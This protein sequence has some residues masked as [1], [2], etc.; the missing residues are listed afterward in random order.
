MAKQRKETARHDFSRRE[1]LGTTSSFAIL[2]LVCGT[3][4]LTAAANNTRPVG[5][6][7]VGLGQA[8]LGFA[9]PALEN[10][11]HCRLTALVSQSIEKAKAVADQLGLSHNVAYSDQAFDC[12][13][14]DPMIDVVYLANPNAQHCDFA[15]RA[16]QAGK[17]VLVESPMA[18][19]SQEAI[20]MLDAC[21]SAGT[22]LA[23]IDR[24]AARFGFS[25]WASLQQSVATDSI[26]KIEL[27]LAD[28]LRSPQDWRTSFASGGGAL[29]GLGAEAVRIC[30][31]IAGSTPATI[32]AQTT[33]R[34]PYLF[35][36]VEESVT[37]TLSYACGKVAHGAVT[38]NPVPNSIE[39]TSHGLQSNLR[40]LD[41]ESIDAS[42]LHQIKAN[43]NQA[44]LQVATTVTALDAFAKRIISS[45]NL[46]SRLTNILNAEEAISELRLL[47]AIR[48]ASKNGCTVPWNPLS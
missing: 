9:I 29:L 32:T 42:L 8:G 43:Q 12:I 18:C 7:V 10:T 25:S 28:T 45:E 3:A 40:C 21:Q 35:N 24:T 27:V 23:M 6:A 4:E 2:G 37:W 36:E 48:T 20:A 38:Y 39:R 41:G 19:D 44:A 31:S 46:T 47:E 11:Q 15:I 30:R 22:Q 26:R 1:F 34:N 16:A 5:I 33:K 14:A 17:H 13:A